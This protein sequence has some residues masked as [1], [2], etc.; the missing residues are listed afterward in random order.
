MAVTIAPLIEPTQLT[1][2]AVSYYRANVPTRID[3]MTVANPTATPRSV[4]IYWV[5]SGGSPDGTNTI[6][7]TRFLNANETWDVSPMIGHT[8]GVGDTIQALA[9]AATAIVIAASGTQVTS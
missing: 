2:A 7:A 9:S 4:T 1:A 6:V 8:L 5:P 3:K